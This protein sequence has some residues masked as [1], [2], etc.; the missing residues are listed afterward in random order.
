M[1]ATWLSLARGDARPL[2]TAWR[3]RPAIPDEA[4]WATFLRNHDELTLDK[5]SRAERGEVFA[6]FGP[7]PDMQV[8]G[9]GLRRRLPPMLGGDQRWIRMAYSLMFAMPGTPTI[10]YGEE[11][12]MGENLAVDDRLAVRTPMQWTAGPTGGFSSAPADALV[13]PLPAPPFSPDDVNVRDARADPDSLL[14][15]FERLVRLRK[16]CPEIAWGSTELVPTAA[17]PVVVMA[18]RWRGRTLL[19]AHNLGRRARTVEISLREG[20]DG[21][22]RDLLR[23][24]EQA[25]VTGGRVR[26]RLA[27][28]DHRWLRLEPA[29]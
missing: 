25:A 15:W 11:L 4:A 27:A 14:N 19:T 17:D 26:L 22:L 6:A 12:G 24:D 10:F 18:H 20:G 13:R 28:H 5:L 2:A 21:R 3:A 1:Q 8:Y 29:E 23:R 7:D 16:E 9:R